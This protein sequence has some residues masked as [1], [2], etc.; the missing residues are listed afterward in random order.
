MSLHRD[1]YVALSGMLQMQ[2]I[3]GISLSFC[4]GASFLSFFSVNGS[5]VKV[6]WVD[7]EVSNGFLISPNPE[8]CELPVASFAGFFGFG[9]S[10]FSHLTMSLRLPSIKRRQ[11]EQIHGETWKTKLLP[12]R[13]LLPVS[14]KFSLDNNERDFLNIL[15]GRE[16]KVWG[17]TMHE[18]MRLSIGKCAEWAMDTCMSNEK[19]IKVN[20][21]G[22]RKW[23]RQIITARGRC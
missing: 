5:Y 2:T 11:D 20:R 8:G 10:G 16:V 21:W 1:C 18:D 12:G 3:L 19:W 7:A 23:T 6:V 4:H 14:W 22:E 9:I 13:R 17:P 15:I